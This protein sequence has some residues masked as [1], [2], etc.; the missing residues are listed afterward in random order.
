MIQLPEGEINNHALIPTDTQEHSSTKEN[1]KVRE[2]LK[3]PSVLIILLVPFLLL[4]GWNTINKL[5]NNQTRK[6]FILPHL[7][8][9][10]GIIT[11]RIR[12]IGKNSISIYQMSHLN[13]IN[14][15]P[16]L[17]IANFSGH[18]GKNTL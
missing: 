18:R 7:L 14:T 1:I 10:P 5:N 8:K 11:E 4:P 13:K 2:H 12:N 9:N 17:H 15:I 6:T 3:L 16:I